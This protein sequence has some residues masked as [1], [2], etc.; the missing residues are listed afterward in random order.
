MC[1]VN[2]SYFPRV[3]GAGCKLDAFYFPF[4]VFSGTAL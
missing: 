1:F 2:K 4:V 3:Q